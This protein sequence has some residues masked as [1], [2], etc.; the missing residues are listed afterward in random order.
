MLEC[1][2]P[3]SIPVH[4]L[5]WQLAY[6]SMRP[7]QGSRSGLNYIYKQAP[8]DP[9]CQGNF[10]FVFRLIS[11]GNW[12]NN[13]PWQVWRVLSLFLMLMMII[14]DCQRCLY[15]HSLWILYNYYCSSNL[16]F[17]PRAFFVFDA[18]CELKMTAWDYNLS[19]WSRVCSYWLHMLIFSFSLLL[20]W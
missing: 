13:N 2:G 18:S 17:F 16:G 3:G 6:R 19:Y 11:Q 9:I 8:F 7:Q 12:H 5:S 15:F 10:F 20:V 1:S 14:I 4:K